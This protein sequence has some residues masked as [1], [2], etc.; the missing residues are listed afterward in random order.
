MNPRITALTIGSELLDG[1]IV[2]SNTQRM[3][4]M[5]SARGFLLHQRISVS[6]D[7]RAIGEAL[8]YLG[9][10]SDLVVVAG[11]LGPTRDDLT[12]EAAA[13]T[14]QRPLKKNRQALE[15]VRRFFKKLG[16]DMTRHQEKQ[17]M[18]PDG[19]KIL[20]N[21]M[22]SAPGFFLQ[23]N[24]C[25]YAFTP[26]VPQEM[27]CMLRNSIIPFLTE[28]YPAAVPWHQKTFK[29]LG[30][31]ESSA[32]NMLNSLKL[33]EPFQIGICVKFPFVH[34]RLS[35]H[36][37]EGPALLNR[38]SAKI[39]TLFAES[40]VAEDDETL[41][42]NVAGL[43]LRSGKTLSLAESCTGGWIAK[44]L[45]DIPGASAFLDRGAVTYSN[46]AKNNWLQV[47]EN[48]FSG[49]GAVSENC[50]LAMVRGVRRA[51][52]TDLALA[53]TG[54]AGP[55]GGTP[56]KPVG[57]VFIGLADINRETVFPFIFQGDREKVR[58]RSA[59][60]ALNL[61]RCHLLKNS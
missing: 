3:A 2:D 38:A 11:G 6:D 53:V 48:I 44:M 33:P 59:C 41:V 46:R 58:L 51:S 21:G 19:S 9:R 30:L 43:L 14:F 10:Q 47:D 52:G 7:L 45:T 39:H 61:L 12:A 29:I 37:H 15:V 32:E 42:G 57:T 40:L 31:P 24:D 34:I 22:G 27:E 50:A 16:R 23:H 20:N 1:D 49:P 36:H 28:N 25:F 56:Q 17:A 8:L 55:G 4:E 5:L 13:L 18:L 26:G 35:L 60:T 54:I